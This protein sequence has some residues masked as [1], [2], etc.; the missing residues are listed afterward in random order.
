MT[1]STIL[2]LTDGGG[3]YL[4]EKKRGFGKG[5]LNGYGGKVVEGESAEDGAIRELKEEAGV[6][7]DPKKLEKV[8]LIDFY[9]EGEHLWECHVFFAREWE[10][11]L[12][13]TEEMTA[14]QLYKFSE[15]PYD[16][17][18]KSDQAWLPLVFSG[19]KIHAK[20]HCPKGLDDVE[21]FEYGPLP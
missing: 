15:L 18:W 16:R 11:G 12:R 19:K 10:G 7:A 2:F 17:M 21:R 9:E 1:R 3:V 6:A 20:V 8:A 5:Y 4:S 14:P 13:E